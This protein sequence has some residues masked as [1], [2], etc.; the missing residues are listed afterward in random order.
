MYVETKAHI[1]CTVTRQLIR[2]FVF[3]TEIEQSLYLLNPKFQASSHLLWLHSPVCV[4]PAHIYSDSHTIGSL[5]QLVCQSSY[6]LTSPA[7]VQALMS[8][9]VYLCDNA[10]VICNHSPSPLGNTEDFDFS[11]SKNLLLAQHCGGSQLVKPGLSPPPPPPSRYVILCTAIT[12]IPDPPG[13]GGGRH[14][15]TNDWCIWTQF[16]SSC[17][18]L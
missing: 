15:V 5:S 3:A 4:R 6:K 13:V 1:S 2:A 11:S 10:P 9:T 16:T 7:A 12:Q 18:T 8:F 14:L 17:Y